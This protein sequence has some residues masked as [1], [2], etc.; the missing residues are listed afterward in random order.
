MA[1]WVKIA[2]MT[3]IRRRLLTPVDV[4]TSKGIPT[5]H[6]NYFLS[7]FINANHCPRDIRSGGY[8]SIE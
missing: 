6:L 5:T 1:F 3:F 8:D 4:I 7:L 2:E